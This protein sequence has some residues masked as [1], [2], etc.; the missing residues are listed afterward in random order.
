MARTGTADVLTASGKHAET[1]VKENRLIQQL[2]RH[3]L[4]KPLL[5]GLAGHSC[6]SRPHQ[7]DAKCFPAAQKRAPRYRPGDSAVSV[8]AG[9]TPS[10][11][12]AKPIAAMGRSYKCP[13]TDRHDCLKFAARQRGVEDGGLSSPQT[14][15]PRLGSWPRRGA[16]CR[17]RLGDLH[18]AMSID[19]VLHHARIGQRGDIAE[20]IVFAGRDLA[21]DAA[22][23]LAR[24]SLRQTGSPLDD[25]W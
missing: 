10:S 15:T 8:G 6:F 1:G 23:D 5:T 17:C 13:Q 18:V 22:H 24:A 16:V 9:G 14:T 11:M 21:Q 4:R 3:I 25:I 12:P 7:T 2:A 19:E 20:C